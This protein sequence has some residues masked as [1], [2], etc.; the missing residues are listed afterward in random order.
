MKKVILIACLLLSVL[1]VNAQHTIYPFFDSNGAVRIET[2][3]LSN[4]A[5][6]LISVFHRA[7]DI[8]WSRVVYRVI[9]M[10][11]KQNYQLYFPTRH[12]DPEY[13]SLFKVILD[14]IVDGMPVYS[15]DQE[16]IK[17]EFGEKSLLSRERIPSFL[18]LDDLSAD[19]SE[20]TCHYNTECSDAMLLNYFAKNDSMVFNFYPYEGFVK[21][22]LKYLIQEIVFFDR[23]NSRL[24]SK[25]IAIAPLQAD[26]ITHTDES[27]VML[28]MHESILFWIPFDALRPYLAKQYMIPQSNDSKR[29]TFDEFFAKKL[30]SSYIFGDSNMY[31]RMILEYT[32]SEVDVKK[33]QQRIFDELLT[34]E[35]DLW[36]Y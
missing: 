24:Y 9:D 22:Q 16:Y 33:E 31:N 20:D 26:K 17:P 25:I 15:K 27:E 36:E 8:V 34:F 18:M 32:R 14:G 23:H 3:E 13:R 29:M 30:Y 35:Q 6:T 10:R 21:N 28:A 4:S 1:S 7:D 5:D 12:D 2:T 19:Y 11:Y